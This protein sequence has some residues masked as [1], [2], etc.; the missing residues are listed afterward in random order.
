MAQN[1]IKG[2]TVEIGGDVTGLQAALKSVNT[3]ISATQAELRDV[4]KL[5]KLDPKNVTLLE[6]KQRL[7]AKATQELTEKQKAL[8]KAMD[9]V[10]VNDKKYSEWQKAYQ[11][12]QTEIKGTETALGNL[13][14]KQREMEKAGDIDTGEYT[15][16]GREI[17][18]LEDKIESLNRQASQTF[19]EMG[20]PISTTQYGSLQ[21]EAIATEQ[22]LKRMEQATKEVNTALRQSKSGFSTF[23]QGAKKAQT[24]IKKINDKV[25]PLSAGAAG[26][27]ASMYGV[28]DS[29]RD[30]RMDLSR[31]DNNARQNAVSVDTARKAWKEFAI[32]T[33]E[34]DSSVEA[35]SNLLAAG[36]NE[37]NMQKAVEGLAGAAQKFSDTL[38]IESLAD[39]LQETMAVGEAT[40]QWAEMLDRL[41]IS[42]DEFNR[43]L[44]QANTDAEKQ[45]VILQTLADGGLLDYYNGWKESEQGIYDSQNAYYEL[46][47]TLSEFGEAVAPV[48]TDVMQVMTDLLNAFNELDPDT[49]QFIIWTILAVAA[50]APLLSALGGL[51]GLLSNPVALA[52]VG[53][54]LALASMVGMWIYV[55]NNLETVQG[56]I[57]AV[58]DWLSGF[59]L[60]DWTEIFGEAGESV[61]ELALGIAKA[62]NRIGDAWKACME[63]IQGIVKGDWDQVWKS[64]V[65][66]VLNAKDA[67]VQVI[68][69]MVNY[70]TSGINRVIR[71][72]NSVTTKIPGIGFSIPTIPMMA[73]GGVL[74]SGSAI[75][76]EAGPELLT[77]SGGR[78]VVQP[79]TNSTT[80][81]TANFGGITINVYS[82]GGLSETAEQIAAEIQQAVQ[83][84]GMVFA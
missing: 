29:T 45:D 68:K 39:S 3:Q 6:Q 64:A 1:R 52:I 10:T 84:K 4:E 30:L 76:G 16:L 20:R 2:I 32:V 66:I 41:G 77:M 35:V 40:G 21:R 22:D 8:K 50:L 70:V 55:A 7:L 24:A 65:K 19:D 17:S 47:Q 26:L 80:N 34:T 72:I 44:Q 5:L 69:G 23:E 12:I 83:R 53:I 61:S 73:S 74:S 15:K 25:K 48:I 27:A 81:Q 46:Q 58:I 43:K 13:I 63:L 38:K 33:D 67:V 31:L 57:Q 78:A 49:Q 75:V 9:G 51:A 62:L 14:K 71:S 60:R 18:T 82:N 59:F 36:F 79:L 54:I 42:Q 37:N 56:R 28:Y 11:K